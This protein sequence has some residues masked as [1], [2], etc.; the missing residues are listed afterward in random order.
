MMVKLSGVLISESSLTLSVDPLARVAGP[1]TLKRVATL[2]AGS[3]ETVS[4]PLAPTFREL[5]FR[6][7][8][9]SSSSEPLLRLIAS[10]PA[11]P[12]ASSFPA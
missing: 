12:V 6:V 7:L 10:E 8:A 4:A 3:T 5:T 1:E 9:L 11:E 2:F